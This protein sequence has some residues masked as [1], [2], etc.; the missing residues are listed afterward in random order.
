MYLITLVLG[1]Q[2]FRKT[3]ECNPGVLFFITDF[4][5]QIITLKTRKIL[6]LAWILRG[7]VS[8]QELGCIQADTVCRMTFS[9]WCSR[10]QI[11]AKRCQ[12]SFAYHIKES[13]LTPQI[14]KIRAERCQFWFLYYDKRIKTETSLFWFFNY[15]RIK[16]DTSDQNWMP[17]QQYNLIELGN[18]RISGHAK[19]NTKYPIE[20]YA[21]Y[22]SSQNTTQNT[23]QNLT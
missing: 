14:C 20:L 9:D 17:K 15:K 16:A 10:I 11:Q 7:W 8:I 22:L 21:E 13:K 2:F 18:G 3:L 4:W 19:S 5:S 6:L 1:F 23:T 12:F